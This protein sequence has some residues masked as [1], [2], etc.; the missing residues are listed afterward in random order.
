MSGRLPSVKPKD[1]LRAFERAG[2][3]VHHSSG[4]HHILKHR[5]NPRLRIVVPL[6]NM[7]IKRGLL[8]ALI[9]DAGLTVER[10]LEYLG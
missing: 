2:F 4:S 9:K 8:H 7:D 3:L 10:F 5:E 1:V 6:H